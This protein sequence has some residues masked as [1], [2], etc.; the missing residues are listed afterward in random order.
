MKQ[1]CG[2]LYVVC[3]VG[4]CITCD[5][6]KTRDA[7]S[8][9]VSSDSI[10]QRHSCSESRAR[11]MPLESRAVADARVELLETGRCADFALVSPGN[12]VSDG[13]TGKYACLA[14]L[15]VGRYLYQRCQKTQC[16]SELLWS[17]AASTT[18]RRR[19]RLWSHRCASTSTQ[20]L[21]SWWQGPIRPVGRRRRQLF[22]RALR[23]W[24]QGTILP[25]GRR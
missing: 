3:V 25:V 20:T 7:S 9:V 14:Q 15:V 2:Q 16:R 12:K 8:W 24:W 10:C 11:S 17:A 6:A 23:S 22:A 1:V 5:N 18:T 21:R 19:C 4:D 13:D